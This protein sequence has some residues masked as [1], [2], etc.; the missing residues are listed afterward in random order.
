MAMFPLGSVLVPGMPLPLHVF[1][2]RYQALV[3]HCLE[4]E[5]EFGVVLIERGNE[6]GGG[7]ARTRVGTVARILEA[8]R[9]DDGRWAIG[10]VGVRRVRVLEWLPDDPFPRAEVEDWPDEP[11]EPDPDRLAGA[12]SVFRRVLALAAELGASVPPA[13]VELADD[14]VVALLQMTVATPFG[15]VDRHDLLAAPGP[16]ERLDLLAELL[17]AQAEMLAGQAGMADLDGPFGEGYG[18][19]PGGL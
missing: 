13:T 15:P 11:G 3:A 5:P 6:V 18:E 4:G 16:V 9:F 1:E 19:D 7:D 2:P 14:P 10:A 8:T 12:V 17:D